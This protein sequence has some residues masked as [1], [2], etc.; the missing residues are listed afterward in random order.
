MLATDEEKKRQPWPPGISLSEN[1]LRLGL[2][3]QCAPEF[4][5]QY[6]ARCTF[7]QWLDQA[8]NPAMGTVPPLPEARPYTMPLPA[9]S[10]WP[11]RSLLPEVQRFQA[12]GQRNLLGMKQ[13]EALLARDQ[14]RAELLEQ[15]GIQVQ[16]AWRDQEFSVLHAN[17]MQGWHQLD[18]IRSWIDQ[19]PRGGKPPQPMTTLA[20]FQQQLDHV[21]EALGQLVHLPPPPA[22]LSPVHATLL[23]EPLADA[24]TVYLT[25]IGRAAQW[26]YLDSDWSLEL[27]TTAID[28]EFYLFLEESTVQQIE[29]HRQWYSRGHWRS[30]PILRALDWVLDRWAK[31]RLRMRAWIEAELAGPVEETMI[32]LSV[33]ARNTSPLV[34]ARFLNWWKAVLPTI[35]RKFADLYTKRYATRVINEATPWRDWVPFVLCCLECF[36]RSALM[37]NSKWLVYCQQLGP[38]TNYFALPD[39]TK[40][41]TL[42]AEVAFELHVAPLTEADAVAGPGAQHPPEPGAGH[43]PAPML[44]ALPPA[45]DAAD[46]VARHLVQEWERPP[47]QPSE[48]HS[49]GPIRAR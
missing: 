9:S 5:A 45:M 13:A 19:S 8:P 12:E 24:L 23:P 22:P 34:L 36:W 32:A 11:C 39:P 48:E 1:V 3:Q 15:V 49:Y 6:W 31:L 7:T 40:P 10:Q 29:G 20:I 46:L 35:D 41:A 28:R 2:H 26:Q 14:A 47:Q 30:L 18:E 37:K 33:L 42:P 17:W 4:L 43:D 27:L 25:A 21:R 38:L 44:L 16:Q